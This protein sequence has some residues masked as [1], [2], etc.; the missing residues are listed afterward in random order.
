MVDAVSTVNSI[1]NSTESASAQ[2]S[3]NYEMFLELLTAELQNQD[4]LEPLDSSEW[5][6]Q[7]VQFS[8]V[9]QQILTNEG[10]ADLVRITADST[11]AAMSGYLGKDV[12]LDSPGLEYKGDDVTWRY[13]LPADAAETD[14]LIQD[15][16]GNVIYSGTGQV[17]EGMHEFTWDGSTSS[18]TTAPP[19]FYS[20]TINAEDANGAAL[21]V[22][23]G[24]RATVTG[25]DLS[26]GET[27][28]ATTAGL[29]NYSQV[30][31]FSEPG[32]GL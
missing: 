1:T 9:E 30:L 31:S 5:I 18:G 13:Q 3:G 22:P 23:I 7:L 21:G 27:G 24:V 19:G 26:Q 28:V 14:I 4:P 32:T 15:S 20:M 25:V 2:L 10:L 6:N 16:S 8:S 29:F 11:S 17:N 12:V